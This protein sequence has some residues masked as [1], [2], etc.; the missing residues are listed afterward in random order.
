MKTQNITALIIAAGL[1]TTAA[2]A[3][4]APAAP[5]SASTALTAQPAPDQ[6]IYAPQLPSG[7][8]LTNAATAQGLTIK[9]ITQ[10][11]H[12][13][14][15]T[16]QTADGQILVV[17]YRLL[18]DAGANL[19]QA[20]APTVVYAVAPSPVYY[21]YDPYDPYYSAVLYPPVSVRLSLGFRTSSFRP[22]AYRTGS[23]RGGHRR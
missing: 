7:A 3:D 2:W 14:R 11:A 5:A 12:D 4:N 22:S 8:E 15:I 6:T 20:A 17:L 23:F 13:L 16:Y 10:S 21:F 19:A 9:Q 18:P 1:L